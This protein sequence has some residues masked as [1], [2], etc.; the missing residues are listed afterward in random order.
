MDI[1]NV[2]DDFKNKLASNNPGE[3]D[4]SDEMRPF[5]MNLLYGKEAQSRRE[6]FINSPFKIINGETIKSILLTCPDDNYG[7]GELINARSWVPFYNDSKSFILYSGWIE[8]RIN[9]ENITIECFTD[10]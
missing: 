4:F 9:G 3:S 10:E 7:A 5:L 8:N 6:I 2:W 1:N